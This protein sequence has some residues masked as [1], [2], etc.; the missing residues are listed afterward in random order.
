LT[1]TLRERIVSII[2]ERGAISV[3]S[4]MELALYDP[5]GG[6]Y[7][8]AAQRSGKAGDFYTS[9]DVS[10][11]FGATIAAQLVEMWR[12]LGSGDFHLVEAGAGNGRLSR[13]I[14]DA[15]AAQHPDFYRRLRVTL[16]ERSDTAGA[17]QPGTLGPHATRVA[18]SSDS[19]PA[20]IDGAIV[21]NEL[22]DALP[23]TIV[24]M[25]DDGFREVG[26]G[27]R[28]GVLVEELRPLRHADLVSALPAVEPGQ[29]IE[30]GCAAC[31]WIR[32][33][34]ASLAR[35]FLMLFDYGYRPS[36]DF[37][38][39]HPEGTLMAYR[40]HRAS[41]A[42]WLND[43]GERDI[44]AHVNLDAIQATAEAHGLQTL[45]IVDQCSFLMS[46]G[47][48]DRI[49]AGHDHRATL[50]RLAA[51]TLIMPGGLGDTMKAMVFAKGV[52]APALRGLQS[53]RLS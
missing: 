45:G 9:V 20:G 11:V 36:A 49:D 52:G 40:S 25:T 7:A 28:D 47:L 16:V 53:G 39:A 42:G 35:G 31:A 44:T 27:E 38:R 24:Q 22:L 46:L 32:S 15:A 18:S 8:G 17:A 37:F 43:P 29:R 30:I 21:A 13:D 5:Q 19:L 12:L 51:R 33:A 34:A 4:F 3:A 14:L 10:P 50:Q 26:V 48:V 23:V 2:R 41:G 6:Y 1:R